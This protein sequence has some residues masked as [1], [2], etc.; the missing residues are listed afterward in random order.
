MSFPAHPTMLLLSSRKVEELMRN[1]GRQCRRLQVQPK[2]RPPQPNDLALTDVHTDPLR[3]IEGIFGGAAGSMR[4]DRRIATRSDVRAEIH[5]FHRPRLK[6]RSKAY[7][8]E[9]GMAI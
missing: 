3:G 1:P 2:G 8:T 7:G 4:C 9:L 5:R 6:R